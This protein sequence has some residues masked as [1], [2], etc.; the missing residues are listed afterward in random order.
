MKKQNDNASGEEP[1]GQ[2][3]DGNRKGP[4][5]GSTSVPPKPPAITTGDI[6][7]K[8]VLRWALEQSAKCHGCFTGDCPHETMEQCV[9]ALHDQFIE[10]NDTMTFRGDKLELNQR[11]LSR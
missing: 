6:T 7:R 8:K 1:Q 2:P 5:A 11:A 10:S 9:E 4:R 3:G